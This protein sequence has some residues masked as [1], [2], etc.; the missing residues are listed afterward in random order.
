MSRLDALFFWWHRRV[1]DDHGGSCK[2]FPFQGF[3]TGSNVVLRG[4]RGRSWHSH[5]SAD[6]VEGRFVWQVQYFCKVF[7]RWLSCFVACAALWTCPCSFL[8]GRRS[9]TR[10]VVLR[11]F[12]E[13]QCRTESAIYLRGKGGILVQICGVWNVILRGWRSIWATLHFTLHTP[14]STLSTFHSTLHH[15]TLYT[16]LIF[17]PHFTLYAPHFAL[18]TPHLTLYTPPIHSTLHT[19]HSTLYT[20]QLTLHTLPSTLRALHSTL[21]TPH[22]ALHTLHFTLHTPHF[23]LHALHSALYTLKLYT[24]HFTLDTLHF[25][26]YTPHFTLYTPHS[27]LHTLSTTIPTQHSTCLHATRLKVTPFHIPQS[28]VHWY[29]NRAKMYKT[30]QIIVCF[31]RGF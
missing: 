18:H 22:S 5:V 31:T 19:L 25:T 28:T 14:H 24:F 20:F 4:R 27:P 13:S 7:G 29:G 2:T 26:L 21:C 12:C 16:L 10:R 6:G 15:S 8:R 3:Q 23:T 30:V 1:Y 11:I 17:T 9:T